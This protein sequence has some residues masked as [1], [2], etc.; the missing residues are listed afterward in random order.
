MHICALSCSSL[1][2]SSFFSLSLLTYSFLF[3]IFSNPILR[4]FWSQMHL[5]SL[6]WR[7]TACTAAQ[8]L[9]SDSRHCSFIAVTITL[10]PL[11]CAVEWVSCYTS[12]TKDRRRSTY[13][14]GPARFFQ[15]LH[16]YHNG[17]CLFW[18]AVNV[19]RGAQARICTD[20]MHVHVSTDY[21]S[22]RQ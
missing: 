19:H 8:H 4:Q 2:F 7:V 10:G 21:S 9:D 20:V 16:L 6:P 5:T 18:C 12:A 17:S 22:W 14:R 1:S 3:L 13:S 11:H 15:A